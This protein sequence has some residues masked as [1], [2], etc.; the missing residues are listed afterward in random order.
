MAGSV[1]PRRAPRLLLAACAM[2][3]AMT[4]ALAQQ[5]QDPTRPASALGQDIGGAVE[6]PVLQSVL[7]APDRK[8][9]IISGQAIALGGQYNGAKLV[10]VSETQVVLRN[11]SE[12]QTLKLFPDVDKHR[13][14]ADDSPKAA[15]GKIHR[16]Q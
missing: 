10:S 5:L 14:S 12:L 15:V 16:K 11:G 7:I 8:V 4:S 6:G 2:G 3:I 1:N 9:A 13:S